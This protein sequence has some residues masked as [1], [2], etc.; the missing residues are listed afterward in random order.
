MARLH[1]ILEYQSLVLAFQLFSHIMDTGAH[2][3][4]PNPTNQPQYTVLHSQQA[5]ADPP[6]ATTGPGQSS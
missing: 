1:D 6:N 5:L 4:T 3:Q 2:L